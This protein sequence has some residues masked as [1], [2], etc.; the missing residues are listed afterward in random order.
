M[1]VKEILI[2]SSTLIGREDVVK[3]LNGDDDNATEQTLNAVDVMVRLLNLVINELACS[4]IP[5]IRLERKTAVNGVI[6]YSDLQF[7][8]LEILK[9]YDQSG[10]DRLL[11]V[12]HSFARV[13]GQDVNIEYAY[14]PPKV[15]LEDNVGYSEKDLPSRVLSYGLCAEYAISQGC[16]KDAVM[17]H[18]RYADA[19]AEICAPKN[20]KIKRRNWL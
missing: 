11:S 7:S 19:I 2:N 18:D 6:N 10:N 14:F 15:S 9:V 12:E 17:W 8:P 4:F 20:A 5:M 3:Y 1:T 13:N 16:F